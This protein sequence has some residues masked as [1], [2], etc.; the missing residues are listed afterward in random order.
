LREEIDGLSKSF[1]EGTD[2]TLRKER[3]EVFR[4]LVRE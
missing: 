1:K 4:P 2:E 3:E